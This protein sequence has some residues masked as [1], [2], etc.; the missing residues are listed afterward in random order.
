MIWAY[1]KELSCGFRSQVSSQLVHLLC[2]RRWPTVF[3]ELQTL[4]WR[5]IPSTLTWWPSSDSGPTMTWPLP[6]TPL[7]SALICRQI[8]RKD[9]RFGR[10]SEECMPFFCPALTYGSGN[11]GYMFGKHNVRQQINTLTAFIVVGQVYGADDIKA[12]LCP[13]PLLVLGPVKGERRTHRQWPPA[14]ALQRHGRQL[15]RHQR[16]HYKRQQWYP[17]SW[18]QH[19]QCLYYSHVPFCSSDGSAYHFSPRRELQGAPRV[20][21]C[22][23]AQSLLHTVENHLWRHGPDH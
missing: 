16:S 13:R 14:P 8:P 15:V 18:P 20:T 2:C 23:A 11:S 17:D 3:P 21:L 22:A 1:E 5:V 4:R 19:V 12:P 6:L 7:S 10:H 9:H